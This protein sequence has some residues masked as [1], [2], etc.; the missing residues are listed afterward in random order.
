MQ[1]SHSRDENL[2]NVFT[3]VGSSVLTDPSVY[4]DVFESDIFSC[5]ALNASIRALASEV[6]ML[7]SGIQIP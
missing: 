7:W 1:I 6:K 3:I 4:R 2:I 5:G